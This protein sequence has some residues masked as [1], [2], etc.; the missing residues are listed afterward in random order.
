MSAVVPSENAPETV[1]AAAPG[2]VNLIGEHTDYNGGFVLPMAIPQT[3]RID[4]TVRQD[5]QVQ[6]VSIT[7]DRN[8]LSAAYR[9]GDEKPSGTWQDYL[10][11]VTSLLAAGG[12]TLQG[13]SARIT[14]DVPLGSGL[15]SSAALEVCL[16][17]ALREAFHLAIDDVMIARLGQRVEREFVGAQVGIM[18]QMASS[19]ADQGVALFLDTR[20]LSYR[21]VRLPD[22]IEV[23]VINSGIRHRLAGGEYNTR[24][25]E[26]EQACDQLGV[27]QLRDLSPA[28]LARI[29]ALPEPLDRRARHVVTENDR[30]VAMV[31]AIEAGDL[32]AMG[33][34]CAESHASMRDDYQVSIPEIDR[35][36]AL[37]Q[38]EPGVFG[39]RLTGGGFGGSIV[40]LAEQGTGAATARRIVQRFGEETGQTATVIMPR[41]ADERPV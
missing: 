32:P 41:P 36:V 10:Q 27:A 26:C 2:R 23:L 14:S 19:L 6:V 22:T 35:L 11:G 20:D 3:T 12:H 38:A 9:L 1:Q 16:L 5:Q 24:R 31:R 15:S 13:F 30:V 17:R 33:R 21:Q 25:A 8:R 4:L 29:E 40:V 7:P 18:D 28:D 37:A 39:A 34:L